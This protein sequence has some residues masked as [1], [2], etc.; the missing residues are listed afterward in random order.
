MVA[1]TYA[2]VMLDMVHIGDRVVQGL[3][4]LCNKEEVITFSSKWCLYEDLCPYW[5]LCAFI[6]RKVTVENVTT[7]NAYTGVHWKEVLIFDFQQTCNSS[8]FKK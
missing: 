8:Y 7:A 5:V 4:T 1:C 3:S 6:K 2:I